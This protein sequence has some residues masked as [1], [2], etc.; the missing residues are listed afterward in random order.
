MREHPT[1]FSTAGGNLSD[2]LPLLE[3]Y[4]RYQF[5]QIQHWGHPAHNRAKIPPHRNHNEKI[6]QRPPTNKQKKA[7]RYAA[8]S[9]KRR[10]GP[11]K[12]RKEIDTPPEYATA[13]EKNEHELQSTQPTKHKGNEH[14]L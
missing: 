2:F 7:T 14:T 5:Y 6:T 10:K 9:D 12:L 1:V 8:D 13:N 3:I 4:R 11:R